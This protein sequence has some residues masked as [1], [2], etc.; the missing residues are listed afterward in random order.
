MSNSHGLADQLRRA[1]ERVVVVVELLP[2]DEYAPGHDVGGDVL[3]LVVPVPPPVAQA[4]DDPGREDRLPRHLHRPDGEPDGTEQDHV[5]DQHEVVAAVRERLVDV[6][7]EPVVRTPVVVL[8]D[9]FRIRRRSAVQ[10]GPLQEQLPDSEDLRTVR[11]LVR[12]HAGV[13]LAVHRDPFLGHRSRGQPQPE[14]EEVGQRR[15]QVERPVG[16][17]AMEVD[18][19]RDDRDVGHPEGCQ[20]VAPPRQIEQSKVHGFPLTPRRPADRRA[21]RFGCCIVTGGNAGPRAGPA[22]ISGSARSLSRI[23]RQVTIH[24]RSVGAR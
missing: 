10:L 15:M 14:T 6:A 4:V 8:G 5:D 1:G 23:A 24:S 13:M 12:L 21:V 19:D 20:D 16:L 3:R 9:G 2:A 11:I 22:P 18:R 17:V 7:L